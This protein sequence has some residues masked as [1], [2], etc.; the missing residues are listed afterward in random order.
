MLNSYKAQFA[1]LAR[2]L[3][4]VEGR[5]N[6]MQF[7]FVSVF[8]WFFTYNTSSNSSFL[9]MLT[10]AFLVAWL[11]I[12]SVSQRMHDFGKSARTVVI[13]ELAL[14]AAALF[15]TLTISPFFASPFETAILAVVVSAYWLYG[16]VVTVFLCVKS[17]DNGTNF[18][19][20]PALSDH[21]ASSVGKQFDV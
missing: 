14:K 19:G 13:I 11:R 4:T 21:T 9:V 17:G 2:V 16:L 18:Y 12:T 15:V 20:V 8:A 7:L 1:D 6:R 10:F 3:K 5:I